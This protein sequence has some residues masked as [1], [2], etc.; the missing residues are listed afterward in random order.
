[1]EALLIAENFFSDRN[2]VLACLEKYF[3]GTGATGKALEVK[4]KKYLKSMT[5]YLLKSLN[6]SISSSNIWK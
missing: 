5:V 4:H 6:W 2:P 1:M 3:V